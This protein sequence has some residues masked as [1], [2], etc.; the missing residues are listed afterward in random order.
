M[1]ANINCLDFEIFESAMTT[2]GKRTHR[3]RCEYLT[4]LHR[5]TLQ[6]EYP[7]RNER[8]ICTVLYSKI[9]VERLR[10][11]IFMART[12]HCRIIRERAACAALPYTRESF[13]S[14]WKC[15]LGR[16]KWGIVS[17]PQCTT[18]KWRDK[19][20]VDAEQTING[21]MYAIWRLWSGVCKPP[22]DAFAKVHMNK[23]RK[24]HKQ[25]TSTHKKAPGHTSVGLGRKQF[26][27]NW[28]QVF[29]VCFKLARKQYR[30]SN[31]RAR[32]GNLRS[33]SRGA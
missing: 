11:R 12:S 2:H 8:M 24:H 5:N 16:C 15:A 20:L 3:E 6:R 28:L 21:R 33:C 1:A 29:A 31:S 25:L 32:E 27:V 22:V 17:V 4:P 7:V 26:S 13:H 30:T 9:S 14:R 23:V 10:Y 19:S 18:W